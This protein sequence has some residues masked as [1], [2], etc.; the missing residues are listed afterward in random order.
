MKYHRDF[1]KDVDKLYRKILDIL[2]KKIKKIKE[3]P[4]RQKHLSG[5]N[6]LY[7]EPITKNFRLIYLLRGKTIWL[8]R[9]SK[10]KGAYNQFQ[11]DFIP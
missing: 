2:N 1:L 9:L 3:N 10:H 5:G 7:R 8:V 11:K 4:E 6:N